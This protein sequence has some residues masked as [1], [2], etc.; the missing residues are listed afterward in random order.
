MVLVTVAK[1]SGLLLGGRVGERGG[2]VWGGGGGG[3]GTWGQHGGP[4]G[5]GV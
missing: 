4:E 2:S 3:R 1:A 5:E